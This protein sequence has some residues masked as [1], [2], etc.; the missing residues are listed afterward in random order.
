MNELK[1]YF[2]SGTGNARNVTRW[3]ADEARAM[4][5]L[6]AVTNIARIDRK[7]IANPGNNEMIGFVGPTHGFNFPPVLVYFF[8]RFPKTKNRN[9]V[10]II[11]TRAG[12]KIGRFFLP[13]LSGIALW[14]SAIV[15]ILKG[16]RIV[17]LRSIDLPSNWISIHPSIKEKV[18]ASI[19]KRCKRITI[20]FTEDIF[21][22]KKNFHAAY[23]I[24]QDL[25]VAPV[26]IL[27]FLIGRF[28]FAK[29]FYAN[30]KC[31]HCGLCIDHCAVH[32]IKV[33]ASQPYW[34]YKCESCM[35]CMNDCPQRAIETGHGY[36]LGLLYFSNILVVVLFWK[37]I[38]SYFII[39]ANGILSE[40]L[41]FTTDSF[42]T[43]GL[44]APGYW[45]IHYLKRLMI[46]KQLIE[47]TSL[48]RY[49]F[50][51]RYKIP[52]NLF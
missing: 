19:F 22:E 24:L 35:K 38:G 21:H 9:P 26:S 8:F 32:A 48:T 43:I 15:L 2:F 13:G 25:I 18:V 12:M 27:Y 14:L 51:H 31:N 3:I 20:S 41:R 29:S 4:H 44:L 45:L 34:T 6:V 36:I 10:F 7:H 39:P 23:D 28:F 30:T 49:K 42:I 37:D 50:W 11:N 47:Y 40:F 1:L 5:I 46:L 17:G 16:Y 52:K 33:V